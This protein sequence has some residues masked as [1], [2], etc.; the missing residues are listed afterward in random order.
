MAFHLHVADLQIGP[1]IRGTALR[2]ALDFIRFTDFVNQL[3]FAGVATALN[4]H[5]V[6]AVLQ[7]APDLVS[8]AEVSFVGAVPVS[9]ALEIVPVKLAV[10]GP[11]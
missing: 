2:D 3:E 10:T 9:G 4:D 7:A 6:S 8:G 5:V 1:V 11:R